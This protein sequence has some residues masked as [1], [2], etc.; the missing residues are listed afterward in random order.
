MLDIR[1]KDLIDAAGI[2]ASTLSRYK[3]GERV[4]AKGSI[5]Y[6]SVISGFQRLAEER[7]TKLD[8]EGLRTDSLYLGPLRIS[9]IL[10]IIFVGIFTTLYFIKRRKNP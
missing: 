2:P 5:Q 1:Y 6:E 3:S 10:A 4:P 8:I 7:N 9:Q